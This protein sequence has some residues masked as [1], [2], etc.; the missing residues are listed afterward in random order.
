MIYLLLAIAIICSIIYYKITKSF[1]ATIL[2]DI[3]AAFIIFIIS[4]LPV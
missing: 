2:Y 4:L 1:L 3:Y